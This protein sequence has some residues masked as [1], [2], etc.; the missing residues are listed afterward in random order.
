MK[1]AHNEE[2]IVREVKEL[3]DA[4]AERLSPEME[5]RL[6]KV[7]R[8]A[9]LQLEPRRRWNPFGRWIAAGSLAA[10]AAGI[11]L[12]VWMATPEPSVPVVAVDDTEIVASQEP[13]EVYENLEFYRWLAHKELQDG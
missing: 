4:S 6:R 7:R 3:L 1:T 2:E 13:L 11:G 8:E 9:L 12:S 5:V 10:V